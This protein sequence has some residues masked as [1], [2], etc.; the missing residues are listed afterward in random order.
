VPIDHH[1]LDVGAIPGG[2]RV[3]L[4]H[5]TPSHQFPTGAVLSIARRCALLEWARRRSAYI[6]E[7]DYDGEFRYTGRRIAALAALDPE[8]PVIYC[9]TF[10]KAL[11]PGMR[12]GF[13]SLPVEL[14]AAARH[15]KWLADGGSSPL[16]QKTIAA[17][18]ATGDYERHIR[19]MSRRYRHRRDALLGAVRRH[20]GGDAVVEGGSGGLHVVLWL[21][22]LPQSR[23]ADLVAACAARDVGVY[24]VAPH[25]ATPPPHAGLLLG[26]GIVDPPAI[27]TGIARLA[28]AY[29]AI[30]GRRGQALSSG[31]GPSSP[32]MESGRRRRSPSPTR[33]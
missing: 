3:R 6:L 26:Y 9:G 14:M 19:R 8:G 13:L 28:D 17:M 27:Q 32:L 25:A 23:V 15:A 2:R 33:P 11:F 10:A 5:V 31:A 18:M 24:S 20:L 21:P 16:L 30:A 22:R 1:G 7:D 29:R 12:L 4:V